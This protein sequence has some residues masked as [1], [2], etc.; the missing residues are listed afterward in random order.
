[1][2]FLVA[3]ILSLSVIAA[4]RYGDFM[5]DFRSALLTLL[6]P[7]ER[8]AQAPK[9][10]YDNLTTDFTSYDELKLENER[11]KAEL[12]LLNAKQQQLLKMEQEVGRLRALL[13]TTGQVNNATFQIA[14]VNYFSNNPLSQ[15]ITIN[16]GRM[17]GVQPK[18]TVIDA[19]GIIGQ[20]VSITPSTSRILLITDPAHQIPVRIQR[21]GQR[22]ILSG[23]GYDATQLNFIP[24]SSEVRVGDL[25]ESSGLGGVFPSG[26]PVAVV[27]KVISQDSAPYYEIHAS[28]LGELHQAQQ[29]L[30]LKQYRD[31]LTEIKSQASETPEQEEH[32]ESNA[33]TEQTKATEN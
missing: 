6:D 9:L 16:K 18:Q 5:G 20:V 29:V 21:T 13:G 2:H 24:K 23:S 15:F 28:P 8:I 26:Y 25:L 31:S 12:L 11:L 33:E 10:I 27:T 3:F 19:K 7:V 14:T 17:D 4:D 22:G 1:M 32:K 30:I